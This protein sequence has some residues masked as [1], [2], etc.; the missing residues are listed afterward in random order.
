M[1][2]SQEEEEARRSSRK[3][4]RTIQKMIAWYP[5]EVCKTKKIP[6]ENIKVVNFKV[7]NMFA[8]T[9]LPWDIKLLVCRRR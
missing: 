1:M 6:P 9:Q 2:G 8:T 3:V 5:R 4:A 7:V